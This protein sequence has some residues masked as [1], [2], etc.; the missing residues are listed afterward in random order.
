[1]TT[2]LR[3]LA[4]DDEPRALA[5]MRGQLSRSPSSTASRPRPAR[6]RRS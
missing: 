6:A 5:D 4:V 2:G 1:M 3:I